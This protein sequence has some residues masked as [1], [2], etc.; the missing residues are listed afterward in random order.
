MASRFL[1]DKSVSPRSEWRR[2]PYLGGLVDLFKRNTD[3]FV[4]VAPALEEPLLSFPEASLEEADMV[5]PASVMRFHVEREGFSH[6]FIYYRT[7]SGPSVGWVYWVNDVIR[8]L[9]L[10][11]A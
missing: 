10:N 4:P 11:N 7:H 6:S 3:A 2:A 5:N 1:A 8:N 9:P